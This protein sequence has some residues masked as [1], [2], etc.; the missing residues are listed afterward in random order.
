MRQKKGLGK[1]A[2]NQSLP[3]RFEEK[4]STKRTWLT[5]VER[6][7]YPPTSDQGLAFQTHA[8]QMI[9][10]G[11]FYVRTQYHFGSLQIE[12]LQQLCHFASDFGVIF[13]VCEVFAVW[14][15]PIGVLPK[16]DF[17]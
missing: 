11:P 17:Q 8:L 2:K 5:F 16:N 7:G 3:D 9:L 12:S 15:T 13:V 6:H 4:D 10:F 1:K 14:W